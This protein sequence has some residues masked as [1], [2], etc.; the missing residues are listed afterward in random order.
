MQS[1]P[2]AS[3]KPSWASVSPGRR[4]TRA[5]EANSPEPGASRWMTLPIYTGASRQSCPTS[6]S[7]WHWRTTTLLRR[8]PAAR[9][10]GVRW[11][12]KTF[13]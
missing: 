7:S 12:G 2:G 1:R 3:S 11:T 13:S 8:Q 6:P 9:R 4:F 10:P 5:S